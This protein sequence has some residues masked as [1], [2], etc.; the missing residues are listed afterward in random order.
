MTLRHT[1]PVPAGSLAV[2][3]DVGG[4]K[5]LGVALRDGE[6]VASTRR[7]TMQDRAA[8]LASLRETADGLAPQAPVGLGV[9]GF[10]STAGLITS[11]P[12]LPGLAGVSAADL[13]DALG[14]PV[15]VGNDAN[16]AA[17]AEWRHGAG[18]GVDDLVLL[19]LGT[20]IGAGFVVGG[21]L[22]TGGAG[23]GGEVGHMIVDPDGPQCPCG[24]RGCWERFASGAALDRAGHDDRAVDDWAR[25]VALGV[26]NVLNLLDPQLVVVAGG[27][28]DA[29][30]VLLP[31]VAAWRDRLWNGAGTRTPAP[32]VA[33]RLG[34]RAGAIGAAL[35]TDSA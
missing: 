11:A 14:R 19:A 15:G 8:L 5:V 26:V 13:A 16:C 33:G 21:R 10:V 35:L 4:T 34:Q 27:V 1:V 18:V 29:A 2:G 3:I 7:P 25:W 22:L 31:R 32:L 9:P 17:L 12:N 6:V 23:F 28:A 20:G 30:D 24:Q